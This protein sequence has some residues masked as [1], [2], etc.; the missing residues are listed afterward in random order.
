MNDLCISGSFTNLINVP[1]KISNM[2]S[3]NSFS[4]KK[5]DCLPFQISILRRRVFS[6]LQCQLQSSLFPS[7]NS[8]LNPFDLK[9]SKN[10]VCRGQFHQNFTRSFCASRFTPILL[11]QGVEPMAKKLGTEKHRF[12]L[13]TGVSYA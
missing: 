10:T 8:P 13:T 1:L 6:V 3:C 5:I 12:G 7:V 9:E 11:A 2:S 4:L